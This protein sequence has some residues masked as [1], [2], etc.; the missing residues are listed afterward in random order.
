MEDTSVEKIDVE[1]LSEKELEKAQLKISNKL[2]KI[3]KKANDDANKF[4]DTYSMETEIVLEIRKK[5]N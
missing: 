1:K 4:L 2:N 3:I 5:Q